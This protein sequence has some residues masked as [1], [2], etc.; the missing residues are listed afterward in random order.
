MTTVRDEYKEFVIQHIENDLD[1]ESVNKRYS[2][3][4]TEDE[5]NNIIWHVIRLY[6]PDTEIPP[7]KRSCSCGK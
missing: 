1:L 6:M 3:L 7:T 5:R 4:L 2:S